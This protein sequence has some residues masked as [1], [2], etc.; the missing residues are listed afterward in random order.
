MQRSTI[1]NAPA[2]K[3]V[4]PVAVIIPTLNEAEHLPACLA[5]VRTHLGPVETI[6]ADGGSNDNTTA[7][8]KAAGAIVL[9]APRG[10]GLQ[11]RAG[12]E[13]ATADWLLF[14][15]ADT[16]LPPES[17][18]TI[19]DFT[20]NRGAQ[21]ATFGFR[22]HDGGFWLNAW[23]RLLFFDSVFTRFGDQGTLVRRS[24]Y[25]GIGGFPPWPLFE[26]VALFQRARQKTKIRRLPAYVTT[27]ARRFR[28]HGL[29]RQKWLNAQ[30]LLRYLSGASPAELAARYNARGNPLTENRGV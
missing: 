15:H 11:Y 19:L 14:L 2:S 25:E 17:A 28:K 10:R 27:S 23:A 22:F 24:F 5:T 29:L 3:S 6:V 16:L 18:T 20:A 26:D 4:P 21:I 9:S 7:I 12:V 1:V 30:L 13:R 8:A